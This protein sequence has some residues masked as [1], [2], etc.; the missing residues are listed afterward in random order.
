MFVPDP[1]SLKAL[2]KKHGGTVIGYVT[3][4]V[5]H[6]ICGHDTESVIASESKIQSA[7]AKQ[8]PAVSEKLIHD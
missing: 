4:S 6:V 5:T 2:V 8:V 1:E 3:K 7:A